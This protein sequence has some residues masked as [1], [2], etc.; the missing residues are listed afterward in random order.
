[1]SQGRSAFLILLPTEKYFWAI[2]MKNLNDVDDLKLHIEAR[3]GTRGLRQSLP[4][5]DGPNC[6]FVVASL[7]AED[8]LSHDLSQRS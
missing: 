1:M 8:G 2:G 3:P 6:E 7:E 4:H 5:D